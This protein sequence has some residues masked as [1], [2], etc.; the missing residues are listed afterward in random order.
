V[1]FIG[2]CPNERRGESLAKIVLLKMQFVANQESH[3]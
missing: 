3:S 2:L 1:A